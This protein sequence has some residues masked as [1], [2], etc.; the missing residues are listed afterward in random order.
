MFCERCTRRASFACGRCKRRFYCLEEH[1]M[2][3]WYDG[4]SRE[5]N[6]PILGSVGK[7]DRDFDEE[8]EESHLHKQTRQVECPRD[9]GEETKSVLRDAL[10]DVTDGDL[11]TLSEDV[12]LNRTCK[13]LLSDVDSLTDVCRGFMQPEQV[14][15]IM[16]KIYESRQAKRN[17]DIEWE[18]PELFRG[19]V[20]YHEAFMRIVQGDEPTTESGVRVLGAYTEGL[21]SDFVEFYRLMCPYLKDFVEDNWRER[22]AKLRRI[23]TNI[24][25]IDSRIS[26]AEMSQSML[27]VPVMVLKGA[28]GMMC[29][30]LSVFSARNLAIISAV[31]ALFPYHNILFPD[32]SK[33]LVD[34]LSTYGYTVPAAFFEMRGENAMW[35]GESYNRFSAWTG[36]TQNYNPWIQTGVNAIFYMGIWAST[37][38]T[39]IMEVLRQVF[40]MLCSQVLLKLGYTTFAAGLTSSIASNVFMMAVI[41]YGHKIYKWYATYRR[42]QR[43]REDMKTVGKEFRNLVI[44]ASIQAKKRQ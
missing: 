40:R 19:L 23:K 36:G 5:C 37:I 7:R 2:D 4:H 13:R 42:D 11:K 14:E 35:L 31:L 26:E 17:V 33:T 16:L 3:D 30:I 9:L 15:Q 32:L 18:I 24:A 25:K 21:T 27:A 22:E 20:Q 29:K 38:S 28:Y 12:D 43:M 8:S 1:M 44:D 39:T 34:M 6:Y 10:G 41:W